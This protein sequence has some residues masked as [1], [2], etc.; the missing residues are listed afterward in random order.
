MSDTPYGFIKPNETPPEEACIEPSISVGGWTDVASDPEN[1]HLN[2]WWYGA[3]DFASAPDNDD[4]WASIR[5][6][7]E[8]HEPLGGYPS[9]WTIELY[10]GVDND[11]DVDRWRAETKAEARDLIEAI[12]CAYIEHLTLER[13]AA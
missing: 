7:N 1:T 13:A 10:P 9:G 3:E 2:H 6:G 11:R 4:E 8:A 5:A 12:M